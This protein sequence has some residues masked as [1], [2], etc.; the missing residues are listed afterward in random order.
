MK[1]K[2][3]KNNNL[4]FGIAGV[5]VILG[6]LVWASRSADVKPAEPASAESRPESPIPAVA[7]TPN[8]FVLASAGTL[9]PDLFADPTAREAYQAARDVPEVLEQL[10]CYCGCM[11]HFGHKNNLFCFKDEHGS[12]CS[13]CEGIA[14]DARKMHK[15]GLSID[16]IK[17]NIRQKYGQ[18]TP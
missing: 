9:S 11:Q 10:P 4:W 2:K 15:E 5:V 3:K 7:L 18:S 6:A 13:V 16:Q 17:E 8:P 1:S 12:E 14:I